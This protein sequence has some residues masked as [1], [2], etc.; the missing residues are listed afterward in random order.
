MRTESRDRLK[1]FELHPTDSKTLAA[2]IAQLEAGRQIAVAR[3]RRLRGPQA[4]AAAAAFGHRLRAPLV[5]IDPS[6]ESRPTTPK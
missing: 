5:L 1:L 2:N 3:A 6:Y 4:P